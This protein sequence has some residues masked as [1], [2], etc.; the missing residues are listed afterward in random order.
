MSKKVIVYGNEHCPNCV[1]LK[2]LFDSEGIRYGH[3]D[4]LAGLAHL[5][6]FLALRDSHPEEFAKARE[7]GKIGIPT[8]VV[9]DTTIYTNLVANDVETLRE[10]VDLDLFR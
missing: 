1:V 10:K 8:V 3:V 6:K 2:E 7:K 5:Q 9:D 4:V